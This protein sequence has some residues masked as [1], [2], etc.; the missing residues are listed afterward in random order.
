MSRYSRQILLPQIG[1]EGQRALA[2]S[3]VLVV[4][5]GA[6]GSTIA[7]LLARA[8]IGHLR[9]VDRDIVEFSNLQRQVLFDESDAISG[10]PKAIAATR[11]LTAVNSGISIEPM[12]LDLASDNVLALLEEVD[13]VLDGTDNVATRYLINDAAVKTLRPWVYAACVGVEGRVMAIDP[14]RGWPCLRCVFPNPPAAGEIATCDTAG[15]L[16]PVASIAASF[17]AAAAIRILVGD[18]SMTPAMLAIDGWDG[19]VRRIEL[20]NARQADCPCCGSKHFEF[21][22]ASPAA[23]RT[24][25]GRDAVQIKPPKPSTLDLTALANR[26]RRLSDDVRHDEVYV[27]LVVP[28]TRLS[29]T[30][31]S[32]GRAIVQGTN[33]VARAHALYDR[34]IGQ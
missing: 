33:D 19:R 25:C 27:R 1:E 30:A 11:R 15:V 29:I 3:R 7:E 24:L 14:R 10:T 20:H 2:E 31:F 16:G 21:L 23:N 34:Y 18:E 4:G 6:L 12:V 28:D 22:D 8:G 5:V 13:L 17:A 32:D 9:L 26:W